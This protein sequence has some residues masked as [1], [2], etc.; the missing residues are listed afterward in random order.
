MQFLLLARISLGITVTA[1]GFDVMAARRGLPL[2]LLACGGAAAAAPQKPPHLIFVMADDQ[3]HKNGYLN[4]ELITP[5]THAI[6]AEGVA[7]T[8]HY[9]FKFCSPTRSSLLSGRLPIHVN[10]ENSATEQ[11]LAGVPVNM[12][13][14]PTVLKK[15]GCEI[16]GTV[17]GCC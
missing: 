2:L 9:V 11:P 12:T 6:V 14:F 13:M 10:M 8:N 15:A 5:H 4:P 16:P 7:L 17:V 1:T 3:G